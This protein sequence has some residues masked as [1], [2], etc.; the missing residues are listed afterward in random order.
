MRVMA[1]RVVPGGREAERALA[2]QQLGPAAGA[3]TVPRTVEELFLFAFASQADVLHRWRTEALPEDRGTWERL[4][5]QQ[6][7]VA[8][9]V[10]R[11]PTCEGATVGELRGF[12]IPPWDAPGRRGLLGR[13][14]GDGGASPYAKFHQFYSGKFTKNYASHP[15]FTGKH[16][17]GYVSIGG[18]GLT[19]GAGGKESGGSWLSGGTTGGGG[20]GDTG[21]VIINGGGMTGGGHVTGGGGGGGGTGGGGFIGGGGGGGTGGFH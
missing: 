19:S 5:T 17:T 15:Q 6:A 1:E 11:C 14:F 7:A 12:E 18:I 3:P 8:G 10:V 13:L 4:Y 16:F 21:G 9:S 20:L 2:A